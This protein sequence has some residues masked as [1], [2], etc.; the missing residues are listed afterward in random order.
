[1]EAYALIDPGSTHSFIA[2]NIAS[3]LHI[4]PGILNEEL[5]VRTPL[6][7]SLVVRTVYR[8]CTVRIDIG[9]FSVDLIVLPLLELDIILGMDWLT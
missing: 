3:C 6:G 8:D 9:E 4:E 2:S 7:E 5:S 1:M